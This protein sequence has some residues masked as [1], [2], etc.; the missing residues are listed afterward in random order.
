MGQN[1]FSSF[2]EWL[3]NGVSFQVLWDN[4]ELIIAFLIGIIN[5]IFSFVAENYAPL[6]AAGVIVW[7]GKSEMDNTEQINS[8]GYQP[9]MNTPQNY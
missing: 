6:F 4:K 1:W 3:W 2:A 5:T 7:I 9:V 8:S